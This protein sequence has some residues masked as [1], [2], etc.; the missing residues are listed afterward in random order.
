VEFLLCVVVV[1]PFHVFSITFRATLAFTAFVRC[2]EVIS[3]C[4]RPMA[5]CGPTIMAP[6][7]CRAIY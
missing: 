3:T 2:P 4:R 5:D 1:E 6:Y 7:R